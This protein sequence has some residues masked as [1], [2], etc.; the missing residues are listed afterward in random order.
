MN[1]WNDTYNLAGFII[2]NGVTDNYIDT[3]SNLFETLYNWNMIPTSL[4]DQIQ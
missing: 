3:D 1:Q 4:W 2:G